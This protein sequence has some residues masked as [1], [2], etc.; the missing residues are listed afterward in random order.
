MFGIILVIM[1]LKKVLNISK[2]AIIKGFFI[3]RNR[4]IEVIG[5]IYWG[6][7]I[8]LKVDLERKFIVGDRVEML[9]GLERY[10]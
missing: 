8:A 4:I 2:L 7:W 3:S 9:H 10:Y 1:G 5:K 6:D